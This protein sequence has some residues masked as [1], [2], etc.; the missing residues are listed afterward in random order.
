VTTS[1]QER[2]VEELAIA[3]PG[4]SIRLTRPLSLQDGS[5]VADVLP[6]GGSDRVPS[7]WRYRVAHDGTTSRMVLPHERLEAA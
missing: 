7:E 3:H 6:E 5:I 2:A 4:R 1:D